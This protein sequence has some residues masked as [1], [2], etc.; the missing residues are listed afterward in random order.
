LAAAEVAS[1]DHVLDVATG[2]GEAAL[3]AL[4]TVTPAGRVIGADI[5]P[6]MLTAARARLGDD[7][8]QPVAADGQ[9]LAFR[10]GSFDAVVCQL[11]LQFFPAPERGLADFR[12]VL[13]AAGVPQY[14]SS[15]LRTGHRCGAYLLMPSVA[16][17]P[18]SA[19]RSTSPSRW[20]TQS[21]SKTYSGRQAFATFV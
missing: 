2:P 20:Q 3:L 12:R 6:T 16:I 7:A 10:D 9:A 5:S 18:S 4:A 1:G 13:R 17:F 11:G 8:F 21:D 19:M 14:A 15:P